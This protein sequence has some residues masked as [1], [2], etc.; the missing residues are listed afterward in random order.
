MA[1]N[2]PR[3]ADSSQWFLRID[4]SVFGPVTRDGLLLWAEQGRVLPSHEVS[5]DK[6]K[7]TAAALVDFLEMRWFVDDGQ[8]ELRG[9]LNRKAAEFLLKSGRVAEGAQIVSMDDV[10]PVPESRSASAPGGSSTGDNQ[11]CEQLRKRVQELEDMVVS[12]RKRISKINSDQDMVTLSKERDE[13]STELKNVKQ[14][15]E[16][17]LRNAEKDIRNLNRKLEAERQQVSKL[18][19]RLEDAF[20]QDNELSILSE[21]QKALQAELQQS[22]QR[23]DAAESKAAAATGEVKRLSAELDRL[24]QSLS[25]N[26]SNANGLAKTNAEL[27]RRLDEAL[28]G[29][30]ELEQAFAELLTESNERDCEYLRQLDELRRG[31]AQ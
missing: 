3:T 15:S 22:R 28:A 30:K 18:E 10:E 5:Q 26:E 23:Q 16:T 13:L 25:D 31:G 19:A 7:W 27:T 24:R 8:G 6:K 21:A 12:L 29:K 2:K 4:G 11:E 9:P 14:Q 17:M 1:N 20:R